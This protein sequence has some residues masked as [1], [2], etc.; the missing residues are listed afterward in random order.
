[1]YYILRDD[2]V[3][4]QNH[5]K[6]F[7]ELV[8]ET[9]D[10]NEKTKFAPVR[11]NLIF[12]MPKSKA[13]EFSDIVNDEKID[14][15]FEIQLLTILS[16]RLVMRLIIDLRYKC[17]HDWDDN[18]KIIHAKFICILETLETSEYSILRLFEQLSFRH[19]KK[20]NFAAML[21]TKFRLRLES[22]SV[23][24]ALK[25]VLS[26]ELVREIFKLERELKCYKV[27]I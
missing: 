8:E 14:T 20:D 6:S 25:C 16:G 18:S 10:K 17:L 5:L 21:R 12:R 19:Y 27:Y 26:K 3:I 7:F 24:E 13:K 22:N 9:I 1:M 11:I 4:I 15:T 2:I 23:S